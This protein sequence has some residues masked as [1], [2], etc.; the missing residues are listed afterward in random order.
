MHASAEVPVSLLLSSHFLTL[1]PSACQSRRMHLD[2]STHHR[3]KVNCQKKSKEQ[4]VPENPL[5]R[6]IP[7]RFV[8]LHSAFVV[9]VEVVNRSVFT[10]EAPP[11]R[12]YSAVHKEYAP[13][14][15]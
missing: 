11:G 10:E 13:A 3:Q 2:S 6:F 4:A 12:R 14:C 5:S 9:A 1:S 8:K 7:G 15:L